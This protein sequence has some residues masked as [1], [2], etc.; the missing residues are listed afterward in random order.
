M[1]QLN[2]TRIILALLFSMAG[3]TTSAHDIEESNEDG[4]TI[5]YCWNNDKTELAVSFLGNYYYSYDN[6]YFGKVV[7]PEHVTY[8]GV[9]Y[10]VTSIGEFAFYNCSGL[11]SVIIPNSVTSI[12]DYAF[13][14]CI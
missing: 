13:Y 7:I 6:E 8:N 1:K 3:I 5:Y 11:T 4:K 9:T 14:Y 12:E 2:M 10:P